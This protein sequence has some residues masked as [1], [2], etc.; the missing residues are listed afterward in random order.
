MNWFRFYHAALHDPKVQCLPSPLFRD[1]VNILCVASEESARGSLPDAEKLSYSLRKTIKSTRKVLRALVEVGL[2]D[3]D[4]DML[5]IH[6]WSLRQPNSDG[7][8]DRMRASRDRHGDALEQNREEQNREEGSVSVDHSGNDLPQPPPAA[9]FKEAITA[10]LSADATSRV[11][12]LVDLGDALGYRR[13]GGFCAAIVKKH[14]HGMVV[15]DAL[16][17]AATAKG[18]PW[19]YVERTLGNEE[20]RRNAARSGRQGEVDAR[21]GTEGFSSVSGAEVREALKAKADEA[22]RVGEGADAG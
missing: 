8:R 5:T 19:E 17:A 10:F 12:R 18:D 2:L 9:A 11:A 16:I 21:P 14:G 4:A 3:E 13:D 15:V 1:W 7:S 6:N 22:A 20:A